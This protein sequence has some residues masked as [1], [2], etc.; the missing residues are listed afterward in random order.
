MQDLR[1]GKK[2]ERKKFQRVCVTCNIPFENI[3]ERVI[4]C[5]RSCGTKG[6][7]HSEETLAKLREAIKHRPLISEETRA[8][9]SASAKTKYFSPEHRR[10]IGLGALGRKK[11]KSYEE[12]YG[13]EKANKLKERCREIFKEKN[14]NGLPI[15]RGFVISEETKKKLSLK[16]KGRYIS[17]ETRKRISL[18]KKGIRRPDMV[19]K[20]NDPVFIERMKKYKIGMLTSKNERLMKKILKNIGFKFVH[21]FKVR[22]IEHRYL[23]DF[24]IPDL[25]LVIECDGKYWHDYPNGKEL[26]HLRTKEMEEKGYNVL[27]FWEKEFDLQKVRQA[28]QMR[29]AIKALEAEIYV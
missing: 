23:A 25:N 14:P 12:M 9:M 28:I 4:H 8:K 16:F 3:N 11:G 15:R 20:W 7:K 21:Q 19:A 22:D 26:D 5:S 27:R 13:I 2:Y 29:F 10:K 1:L 6:R 18:G 17:P 24:Y